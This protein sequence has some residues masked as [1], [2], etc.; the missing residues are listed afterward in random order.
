MSDTR[1]PVLEDTREKLER[2]V[3][4]SERVSEQIDLIHTILDKDL[5]SEI[6]AKETKPEECL[7]NLRFDM[8][9]LATIVEQ[10][11]ES[12]IKSLD[13]LERNLRLNEPKSA[14]MKRY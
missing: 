5:R 11:L 14:N 10:T 9:K 8:P 12:S 4:L 1:E 2:L 13:I 3:R 7:K 6:K